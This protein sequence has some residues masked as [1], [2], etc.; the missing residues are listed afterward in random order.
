MRARAYG[1]RSRPLT[2]R[3][4]LVLAGLAVVMFGGGTLGVVLF[5]RSETYVNE[6]QTQ[7]TG[8]LQAKVVASRHAAGLWSVVYRYRAQG[9]TYY[10]RADLDER[11]W[12]SGA[13]L[14]L[15]VDPRHPEVHALEHGTGCGVKRL[16]TGTT[17]AT[18]TKPSL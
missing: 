13:E 15:C 12:K 3:S 4:A 1:P 17:E 6:S 8:H 14:G 5:F 10:D 16:Y 11:D 7:L 18:R 9:T 2:L